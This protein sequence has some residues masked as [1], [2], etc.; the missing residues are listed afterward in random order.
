MSQL[1]FA[2]RSL[3]KTPIVT[4]VAVLSVTLGIGANVAIFSVFNQI[5]LRPLPVPEPA[6]LVNL[7]APGPRSGS[8]SCGQIGT[9]DSLFSYPM[10]RDLQRVQT[11]FTD[12]AAHREFGANI[13]YGGVSEGGDSALVSGSYFSVLELAP[14]LGRL[15]I[16]A[17]ET[18]TER[19]AVLSDE[20]WRRRFAAAHDIV[21]KTLVVNGQ[22]LTV[23]GVAPQGFHGITLGVRPRV[24]VPIS[25]R[26]IVVPRWKGL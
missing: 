22:P 5:L 17:D 25:T 7:V 6:R 21:G 9:C 14:Q 23:V 15:I 3:L 16:P 1:R 10:F 18:G 20:Y 8:V 4:A 11:S 12:I 13:A 24:Y 26:E 2:L 19:V